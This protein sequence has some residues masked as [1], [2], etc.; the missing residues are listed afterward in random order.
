[1]EKQTR[2]TKCEMANLVKQVDEAYNMA[3]IMANRLEEIQ[4][5]KKQTS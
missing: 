2:V 3:N 1:M 5:R 4:K